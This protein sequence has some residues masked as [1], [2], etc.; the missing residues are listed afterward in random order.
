MIRVD[1]SAIRI[2]LPGNRAKIV[3]A[4]MEIAWRA[5]A[6]KPAMARQLRHLD[7]GK[8]DAR[9]TTMKDSGIGA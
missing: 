7:L 3:H 9:R 4:A 8:S 1:L 2:L 6:P 5:F